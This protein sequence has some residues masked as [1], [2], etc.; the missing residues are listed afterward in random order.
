M[1]D[2]ADNRG[3]PLRPAQLAGK[4][5]EPFRAGE[6]SRPSTVGGAPAPSRQRIEPQRKRHAQIPGCEPVE[7]R[8]FNRTRPR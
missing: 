7:D 3:L 6:M 2:Q 4:L 1:A 5:T 8:R